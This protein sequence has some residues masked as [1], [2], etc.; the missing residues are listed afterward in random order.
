MAGVA[1]IIALT[2]LILALMRKSFAALFSAVANANNHIKSTESHFTSMIPIGPRPKLLTIVTLYGAGGV[3]V[4]SRTIDKYRLIET[5]LGGGVVLVMLSYRSRY[6]Y[7][8]R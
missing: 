4:G 1:N 2:R 5:M 3:R 7:G 8:V 6:I